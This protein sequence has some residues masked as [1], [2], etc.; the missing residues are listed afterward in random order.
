MGFSSQQLENT[1]SVKTW[2]TEEEPT[3]Y[4]ESW[5]SVQ[6]GHAYV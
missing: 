6:K 2:N 3:A 5:I 4:K 1:P